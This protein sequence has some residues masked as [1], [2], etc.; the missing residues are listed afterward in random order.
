[1]AET[2]KRTVKNGC[3]AIDPVN[4]VDETKLGFIDGWRQGILW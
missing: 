3:R 1:M 2:R 4:S